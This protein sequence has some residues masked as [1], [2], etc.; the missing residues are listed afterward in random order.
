M[1]LVWP[2]LNQHGSRS[3]GKATSAGAGKSKSGAFRIVGDC[4]GWDG[5]VYSLQPYTGTD[6][7]K[8]VVFFLFVWVVWFVLVS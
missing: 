6:S 2:P 4:S 5:A 3:G 8:G 1:A 7:D